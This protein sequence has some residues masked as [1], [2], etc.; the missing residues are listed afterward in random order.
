MTNDKED[1]D[2]DDDDDED[3]IDKMYFST[4]EYTSQNLLVAM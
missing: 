2:D 1:D 4:R 3:G